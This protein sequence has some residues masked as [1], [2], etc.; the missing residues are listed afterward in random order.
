[1][2]DLSKYGL[3]LLTLLSVLAGCQHVTP[4]VS[5]QGCL[6]SLLPESRQAVVVSGKPA[7]NGQQVEVAFFEKTERGW[8]KA[9]PAV[10]G[11]AGRK[12]LAPVGEKREGDGRTPSGVFSLERGFGYAPL[13]TRIDY[14][15]LTDD[16]IWVD[17][18]A[19]PYYNTMVSRQAVAANSF[20][21]MR[22]S[23][24]LYKYGVV[25]EYNTDPVVPGLGSAIF[26]HIW[27][28]PASPTAGCVAL[29]EENVLRLLRWLD[30]SKK[31]V[32]VIGAG[33]LCASCGQ[34]RE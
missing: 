2:K 17:D 20:E 6:S 12:G 19:S 26:I 21:S 11:T 30:P 34:T 14:T 33:T 22:R 31:P 23:G 29:A 18:P 13:E 4:R 9:F 25:V 10:D 27:R 5:D 7:G 1:M 8:E 28:G 16:L 3:L 15:V 24:D 32:A